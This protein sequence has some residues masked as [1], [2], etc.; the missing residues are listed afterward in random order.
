[1]AS[2]STRSDSPKRSKSGTAVLGLSAATG[3]YVLVPVTKGSSAAIR[4]TRAA[5]RRLHSE[6]K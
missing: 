3:R 4:K 5:V 2:K 1:M 6:K